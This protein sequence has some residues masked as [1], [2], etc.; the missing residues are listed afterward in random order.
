LGRLLFVHFAH[1]LGL[2]LLGGPF[3]AG[4]VEASFFSF[5]VND[6]LDLSGCLDRLI[7]VGW[8]IFKNSVSNFF[9][10]PA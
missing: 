3:N 1:V 4:D 8:S 7:R 2:F 9:S 10:E 5:I 6:T